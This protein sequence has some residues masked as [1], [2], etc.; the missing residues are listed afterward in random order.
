MKNKENLKNAYP[1]YE[2]F[3]KQTKYS[4]LTISLQSPYLS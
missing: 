4:V 3:D 1:L 2:I